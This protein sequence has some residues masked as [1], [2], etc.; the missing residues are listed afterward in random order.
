[1]WAATSGTQCLV[2]D[3]N[4]DT[5]E[6]AMFPANELVIA[7]EDAYRRERMIAVRPP[8]RTRRTH[9]TRHPKPVRHHGLRQLHVSRATAV[10]DE[11]TGARAA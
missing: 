6:N 4:H 8:R 9:K 11:A 3:R 5:E 10:G 1:M 7:A 2:I